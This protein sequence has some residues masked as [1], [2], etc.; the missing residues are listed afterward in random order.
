VLQANVGNDPALGRRFHREARNASA[1]AHPNILSIIDFGDDEGL[2]YIAMEL[3][4][5]RNLLQVIRAEWPFSPE[6]IGHIVGQVLGALD[7]AHSKE[8]VHRDLKPENVMLTDVRGEADFVKV[9]DFGIA[10]A[11][12]EREGEGTAITDAGMICGTP[13]YMSPEQARGESLDGR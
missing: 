11:I 13:E 9:C 7:E 4:T 3:L 8:I 12:S 6:R 1:L 10:K 2:L 5:G